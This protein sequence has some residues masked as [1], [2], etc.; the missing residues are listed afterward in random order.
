MT[1]F[2]MMPAAG[3]LSVIAPDLI[4]IVLGPQWR[5]TGALLAILALR[6]VFQVIEGSQGWLH[7]SL[8]RADRWKNW[9]V[10]TAVVQAGAVACGI[11]FGT[12][13]VAVAVTATSALIALPSIS[14]AGRP[15][16]V[17]VTMV[18]RAI[19]PQ[20]LG[21]ATCIAAGWLAKETVLQQFD[22]ISRITASVVLCAA[23]YLLI[24]VGVFRLI[25]PL[26][27]IL[28]LIHQLR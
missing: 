20:F 26:G 22:G 15:G 2:F 4:P 18:V 9:G 13:G 3:V 7:L 6:G 24:V 8:G 16:G 19:G 12:T 17:G 27:V 14:Y 5:P 11:P 28:R 10:L 25:N 21:T 1:A 23:V